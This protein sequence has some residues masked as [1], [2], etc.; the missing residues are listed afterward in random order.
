MLWSGLVSPSLKMP[1]SGLVS[2][3][4]DAGHVSCSKLAVRRL[5][6]RPRGGAKAVGTGRDQGVFDHASSPSPRISRSNLPGNGPWQWPAR[7]TSCAAATIA[8]GRAASYPGW[9]TDRHDASGTAGR[10]GPISPEVVPNLTRRIG[11]DRH[12]TRQRLVRDPGAPRRLLRQSLYASRW[13]PQSEQRTKD[14]GQTTHPR[15][16]AKDIQPVEKALLEA[17]A[18]DKG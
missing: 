18:K 3:F 13:G 6:D 9:T 14:N 1:W 8:G 4:L 11:Q 15:T 17:H 10:S 2:R 7:L 5:S 16:A 12:D